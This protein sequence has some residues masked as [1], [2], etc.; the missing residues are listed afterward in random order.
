MPEGDTIWR[1]ARALGT[2][3]A[4]QVVTGFRTTS[5]DISPAAERAVR[6]RTVTN[7]EARGKHLLMTFA[8]GHDELVLHTHM[9]MNG[10][11][12]IYRPGESWRRPAASA[13]VVVETDVFVA[14]CFDA[15]VIEILRGADLDRHPAL[16]ALGPDAMADA[17]D[18]AAALARV[19]AEPRREIAVALLDQRCIAGLGNVLKSEALFLARV[20]PFAQVGHLDDAPLRGLLEQGHRLLVLNRS[21]PRRRTRFVLDARQNLWVYG[22]RGDP[23]LVCGTPIESALQGEDARRTYWCPRCQGHS[24]DRE[25]VRSGRSHV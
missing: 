5:P 1:A 14:P 15:P 6:G 17:F 24:R 13:R 2:A 10:S 3:L 16:K 23:C 18:T 9:R 12:H 7:V 22:R 11:W 21:G 19:R 8:R 25:L 20:S 4:G